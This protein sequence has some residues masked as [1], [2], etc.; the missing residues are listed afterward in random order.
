MG[1]KYHL[2]ENDLVNIRENYGKIPNVE[3]LKTLENACTRGILIHTA[4][5]LGIRKTRDA[6]IRDQHTDTF[7]KIINVLDLIENKKAESVENAAELS[8][9]HISTFFKRIKKYPI[10]EER[11]H[12]IKWNEVFKMTCNKCHCTL[13]IENYRRFDNITTSKGA[14]KYRFRRCDD[15][16]SIQNKNYRS[17]I[18]LEDKIN[19]IVN[20]AKSRAKKKGLLFSITTNDIYHLWEIQN[21]RCF[22]TN[23]LLTHECGKLNTM[24][25]DRMDSSLGYTNDNICLTTWEVNRLKSDINFS[26]FKTICDSISNNLKNLKL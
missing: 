7:N 8:N 19:K 25:I 17:K 13:S 26:R 12:N 5:K 3:L 21:H 16:Y 20:S 18:S 10:L 14:N 11:L 9:I 24:S 2:S 23:E 22:Y 1:T 15:C 6:I 4:K